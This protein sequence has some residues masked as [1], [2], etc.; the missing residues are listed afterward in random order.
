M[1]SVDINKFILNEQA[2]ERDPEGNLFDLPPW[3]MSTAERL[4]AQ[5]GLTMTEDHWEVVRFLRE[6]FRQRGMAKSGRVLAD[7]L[8]QAFHD[9]GGRR[10]LYSL[11]P[12]GPVAQGSRIAA[13]PEPAYTSD[14]SFGSAE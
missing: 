4:A 11:F 6:R 8:D 1:T 14:P 3:D 12:H 10:Y 2:V 13:L 9:R 7:E 5:E